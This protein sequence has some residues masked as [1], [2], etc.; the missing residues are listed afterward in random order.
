M[1]DEKKVQHE[2]VIDEADDGEPHV[3]VG[4]D[5]LHHYADG[6]PVARAYADARRREARGGGPA[7]V[8]S[9]TF[10]SGWDATFGA[11]RGQA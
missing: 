7:M 9:D 2:H 5:G 10:R 11:K 4:E 8:A 3:T 1:A 6:C